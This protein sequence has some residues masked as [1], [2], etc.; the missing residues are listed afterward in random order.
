MNIK[1]ALKEKNRKVKLANE[2]YSKCNRYNSM[3]DGVEKPYS[4]REML[5]KWITT[6]NE[7]V[8]LKTKI[9]LANA[10]VYEKIFRLSELKSMISKLQGLNVQSGKISHRYGSEE[11]LTMVAEIGEVEKDEIIKKLESEI[12]QIQDE[13]DA[14]NAT[15]VI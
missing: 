5:D 2:F 11:R 14:H 10:V 3:E 6:T 13:L 4:S 7:L 12:E 1:K 8:Q 9:H 15:T